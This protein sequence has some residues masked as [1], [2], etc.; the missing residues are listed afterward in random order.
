MNMTEGRRKSVLPPN[1]PPRGLSRG[2]AAEYIGIST[3][4]FDQMVA[5]RRMPKPKRI[6]GRLVWDRLQLDIAFDGLPNGDSEGHPTLPDHEAPPVFA[7]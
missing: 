5:D 7:L 6:D 4:K 3:T 1:L 2:K